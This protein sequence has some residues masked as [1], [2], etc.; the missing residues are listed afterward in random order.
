MG[1]DWGH[2]SAFMDHVDRLNGR[3]MA[4]LL[5]TH[6]HRLVRRY[7]HRVLLLRDGHIAVEGSPCGAEREISTNLSRG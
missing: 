5:I 1:Q 6:D 4:I 2:L 3:G 7:A